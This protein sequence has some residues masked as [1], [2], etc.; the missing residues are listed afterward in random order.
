MLHDSGQSGKKT[1]IFHAKS[2]ASDDPE[3]TNLQFSEQNGFAKNEHSRI[4]AS[5]K[6]HPIDPNKLNKLKN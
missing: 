3:E 2:K 1:I 6:Y 5:F 4:V